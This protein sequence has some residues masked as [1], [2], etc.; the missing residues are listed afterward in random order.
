VIIYKV[1]TAMNRA[2]T[3]AANEPDMIEAPP[4]TTEVVDGLADVLGVEE[5][6]PE[7][8]VAIGPDAPVSVVPEAEV[9]ALAPGMPAPIPVGERP[10]P[11]EARPV[12]ET[13]VDID[14]A[15]LEA[16]DEADLVA[17]EE[18]L[19]EVEVVMLEQDKSKRGVVL[20]VLPTIPKDGLGV[21]P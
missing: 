7:E 20:K 6:P 5:L 9:V 13:A 3:P 4:V 1:R 8:A 12:P 18:A 16:P 14:D 2:H 15:T 21:D 10:L 19:L 17:D 11:D